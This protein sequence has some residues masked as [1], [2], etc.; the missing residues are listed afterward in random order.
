MQTTVQQGAQEQARRWAPR[1]KALADES[2]LSIAL[3][4]V[5]TTRTV[6]QLE[7]LTGLS[8]ALVSYHLRLLK[9]TG[10][11][12]VTPVGRSNEYTLCCTEVGDLLADLAALSGER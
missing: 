2:R 11:V 6:R 12:T 5:G 8:Q 7:T 3:L 10:L 1:L 4:L 9:E